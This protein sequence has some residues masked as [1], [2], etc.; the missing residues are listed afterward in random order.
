ML[1]T[2]YAIY[3]ITDFKDFREFMGCLRDYNVL[4]AMIFPVLF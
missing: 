1:L 2:A 3:A 4:F